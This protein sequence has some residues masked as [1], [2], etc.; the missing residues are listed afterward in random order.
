MTSDG[1]M[2]CASNAA[3]RARPS[4]TLSLSLSSKLDPSDSV[5]DTGIIYA[6]FFVRL[7]LDRRISNFA[8]KSISFKVACIAL[9]CGPMPSLIVAAVR[10]SSRLAAVFRSSAASFSR[11]VRVMM[12]PYLSW[13]LYV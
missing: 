9:A 2:P 5:I 13:F 7:S 10:L 8:H 4:L 11:F 3:A 6:A 12:G 1:V